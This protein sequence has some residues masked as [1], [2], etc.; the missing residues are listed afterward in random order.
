M[1]LSRVLFGAALIAALL[2]SAGSSPAT[3]AR[4]DPLSF[5]GPDVQL[6]DSQRS[7]LDEGEAIAKTL[8]S[9]HHELAVVA[10]GLTSAT[11]DALVRS[12]E[13]IVRLKKSSYVPE[14]GR[15]SNPPRL[16]DLNS[17]TLDSSEAD[18]IKDCR[19]DHCDLK[20]SAAEIDRL[21][22]V[23]ARNGND[24][25]RALQDDFRQLILDRVRSYLRQGE[26]GIGPYVDRGH[27]SLPRIFSQL[28]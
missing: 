20:L 12:V 1:P 15:F 6:S 21:Q 26:R 5:F 16:S 22:R 11:P 24:W 18:A 7:R 4:E 14:I 27:E 19:P 23:I 28:L 3:A 10:V 8:P 25:R 13:D 17:L 2:C 9:D